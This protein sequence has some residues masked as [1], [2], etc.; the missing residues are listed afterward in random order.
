M[1][2]PGK[3]Q[4]NRDTCGQAG[5]LK[6]SNISPP[7]FKETARILDSYLSLG[8]DPQSLYRTRPL[9]LTFTVGNVVGRDAGGDPN[10]GAEKASQLMT[11]HCLETGRSISS[12]SSVLFPAR[13][14]T[15]RVFAPRHTAAVCLP[16]QSPGSEGTHEDAATVARK[17]SGTKTETDMKCVRG[18]TNGAGRMPPQKGRGRK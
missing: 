15:W 1:L 13:T 6:W 9:S 7:N 4:V 11:C 14:S 18:R 12:A 5:S 8:S 17:K 2:K 3:S 16:P 10:S